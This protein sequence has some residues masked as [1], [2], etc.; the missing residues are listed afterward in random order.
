[1]RKKEEWIMDA[2]RTYLFI[3]AVVA[4]VVAIP[5]AVHFY[6][7][8]RK[9]DKVA[10]AER[11]LADGAINKLVD[12]LLLQAEIINDQERQHHFDENVNRRL[13]AQTMDQRAE[14]LRHLR[15]IAAH[16]TSLE[17]LAAEIIRLEEVQ[18]ADRIQYVKDVLG[19]DQYPLEVQALRNVQAG[20]DKP[21]PVL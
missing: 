8:S 17:S 12:E 4:S 5:T 11:A 1:M 2:L 21:G 3:I 19:S 6:L 13:R 9:A 10:E 7:V 20:T 18:E 16:E 14:I 15:T